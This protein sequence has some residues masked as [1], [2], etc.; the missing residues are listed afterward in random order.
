MDHLL[1]IRINFQNKKTICAQI[2]Q[3]LSQLIQS[4]RLQPDDQ[5]PPVR[6]LADQLHINFNT[7]ARAYRLLDKSG[8]ISTQQGRGTYVLPRDF[9]QGQAA[10]RL[11]EFLAD[12]EAL[13]TTEARLTGRTVEEIWQIVQQRH[14]GLAGQKERDQIKGKAHRHKKAPTAR[15]RAGTAKSYP[16]FF[17][18][19]KPSKKVSVRQR[20]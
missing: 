8:W 3:Q 10:N 15:Q 12:I 19:E 13:V 14:A 6:E 9:P 16:G 7:V 17:P 18:G 2:V 11:D 5:L 1:E 20:H 4:G